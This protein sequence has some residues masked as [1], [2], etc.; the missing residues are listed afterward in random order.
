MWPQ[1]SRP[2]L[3]Y[4]VPHILFSDGSS[5]VPTTPIQPIQQAAHV[6]LIQFGKFP[7]R[8]PVRMPRSCSNQTLIVRQDG[9]K[10]VGLC[11][12]STTSFGANKPEPCRSNH[13]AATADPAI[14]RSTALRCPGFTSAQTHKLS[15]T[16]HA[17]K[18]LGSLA[19][20]GRR[21]RRNLRA[22]RADIPPGVPG[23]HVSYPW[24]D[25]PVAVR[26]SIVHGEHTSTTR[27]YPSWQQW[28]PHLSCEAQV[29]L[30]ARSSLS[31][32][33]SLFASPPC[34]FEF[35]RGL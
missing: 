8:K 1:H 32:S 13:G 19:G 23:F 2:R 33:L 11:D 20:T 35:R 30:K 27:L 31:L 21:A 22:S 15:L 16:S 34:L 6:A 10:S 24:F 12:P 14:Q 17:T 9:L 28:A 18:S 7:S 4:Y 3:A 5:H 25:C 29:L 26:A